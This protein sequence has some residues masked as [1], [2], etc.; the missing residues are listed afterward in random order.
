MNVLEDVNK[1]W[2]RSVSWE[3]VIEKDPEWIVLFDYGDVEGKIE[4]FKSHPKLKDID[5]VKN[6]CFISFHYP[7][8]VPGARVSDTI[9]KMAM[10][11]HQKAFDVE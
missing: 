2:V 7:A 9:K 1:T 8:L 11:F 4:F 3:S 5:A 6:N 10:A